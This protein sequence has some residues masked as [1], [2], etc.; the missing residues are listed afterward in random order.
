MCE[1]IRDKRDIDAI[2]RLL[3]RKPRDLALFVLGIHSGLRGKDLLALVWADVLAEDGTIADRVRVTESKTNK[4]RIVVLQKPAREALESLLRATGTPNP[5][6]YV[7]RSREGYRKL[8]TDRLRQLIVSWTSAA[9]VRGNFGVRT[10]RKT[11][12]YQLRKAGYDPALL[13]RIFGHSSQAI[14]MRYLGIEQEEI[15]EAVLALDL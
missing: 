10:L 15:N 12:G 1:P 6:D 8:T 3:A 7:F 11:F 14:T 4:V 2:K 13:M 5:E 9:K